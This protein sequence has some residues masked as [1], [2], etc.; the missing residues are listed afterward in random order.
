MR[1]DDGTVD[2]PDMADSLDAPDAADSACNNSW[3]VVHCKP[4]KEEYAATVMRD[5]LGLETYLP[6]V[7][8]SLTGKKRPVAFFP[9]YMFVE[10]NLQEVNLSSINSTPGVLKLLQP[11][12]EPRPIPAAVVAAIRERVEILNAEGGFSRYKFHPGDPVSLRSGPLRGLQA[13]FIGPMPAKA[14]VK[15]LLE[16]LGRPNEVQVDID[17]LEP[18]KPDAEREPDPEPQPRGERRTRGRGRR[19]KSGMAPG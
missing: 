13:V 3:Y 16:F 6:Q 8:E 9:G 2:T 5:N 12:G 11:G 17:V 7:T 10:A 1:T 15:V 4:L 18:A 19:I 14:R